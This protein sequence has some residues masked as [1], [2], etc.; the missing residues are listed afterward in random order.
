MAAYRRYL[1]TDAIRTRQGVPLV[2]AAMAC[3]AAL[4]TISKLVSTAVPVA[5]AICMRFLIQTAVTGAVVGNP[6]AW[7]G[8]F[9]DETS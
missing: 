2:V 8:G 5:V 3:F 4:D 6:W 9:Q 1:V 7:L